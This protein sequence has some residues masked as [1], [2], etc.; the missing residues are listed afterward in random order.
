[1]AESETP[2]QGQ[3]G[4]SRT[5]AT[6]S[7]FSVTEPDPIPAQL[8]RRRAA[9]RRMLPPE[10]GHADPLDCLAVH[11]AARPQVCPPRRF[12]TDLRLICQ[13]ECGSGCAWFA[14]GVAC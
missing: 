12:Q 3:A 14:E 4:G 11:R 9:A 5:T 2:G 6:K 1:M 7:G 8:R 10:C 13:S